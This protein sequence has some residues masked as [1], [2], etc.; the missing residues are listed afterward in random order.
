MEEMTTSSAIGSI[1]LG[2]SPNKKSE[3]PVIRI[4]TK[5]NKIILYKIILYYIIFNYIILYL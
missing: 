2:T 3:K 5:P 4:I 1:R